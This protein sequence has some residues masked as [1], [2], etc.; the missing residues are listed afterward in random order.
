MDF[1][2]EVVVSIVIGMA[3]LLIL[4]FLVTNQADTAIGFIR[5]AIG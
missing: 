4:S 3:I 5:G 2:I 1:S